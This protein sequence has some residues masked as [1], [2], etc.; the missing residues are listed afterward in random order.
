MLR[1][2]LEMTGCGSFAMLRIWLEM[3]GLRHSVLDKESHPKQQDAETIPMAIG[4][5]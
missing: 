3:T 1:T 4:T 2:W 5:T